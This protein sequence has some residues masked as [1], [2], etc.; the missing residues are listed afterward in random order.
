[1]KKRSMKTTPALSTFLLKEIFKCLD[2]A[3]RSRCARVC[4]S[5]YEAESSLKIDRLRLYVGM[6]GSCKGDFEPT[7]FL[8]AKSDEHLRKVFRASKL[9]NLKALSICS[10]KNSSLR[11]PIIDLGNFKNLVSLELSGFHFEKDI[12]MVLLQNQ[13]TLD[14]LETL[15]APYVHLNI[16]NLVAPNLK[17]IRSACLLMPVFK[18]VE[19]PV[20]WIE[21][22]HRGTEPLS[23]HVF[24]YLHLRALHLEVLTMTVSSLSFMEKLK[25]FAKLKKLNL[26]ILPGHFTSCLNEFHA[27]LP[28]LIAKGLT[29][30]INGLLVQ[31]LEASTVD[32]LRVFVDQPLK[33]T[34]QK[35]NKTLM[36]PKDDVKYFFDNF[37]EL[38][39]LEHTSSKIHSLKR[40]RLSN[41]SVLRYR[42]DENSEYLFTKLF[43]KVPNL[44]RLELSEVSNLEQSQFDLLPTLWPNLMSIDLRSTSMRRVDVKFLESFKCLCA[45]HFE[46]L[47]FLND[48]CFQFVVNRAKFLNQLITV[49][50]RFNQKKTYDFFMKKINKHPSVEFNIKINDKFQYTSPPKWGEFKSG[51]I[52]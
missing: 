46:N 35:L 44:E 49:N 3:Q 48:A 42:A 50:C 39:I 11:I 32:D 34:Y 4:K 29:I 36:W 31:D 52:V 23:T 14:K 28:G 38:E 51:S 21:F 10:F 12:F 26:N 20:T 7:E 9:E 5:W 40:F 19:K 33:T 43:V 13:I 17:R 8:L 25:K 45:I 27:L 15:S 2:L 6:Q 1:M 47:N 24:H 18:G 30:R 22:E 37:S 16:V 41:V